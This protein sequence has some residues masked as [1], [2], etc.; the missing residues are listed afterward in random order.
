MFNWMIGTKGILP[1]EWIAKFTDYFNN[2][3]I[4]DE[5]TIRINKINFTTIEQL[6]EEAMVDEAVMQEVQQY[7]EKLEHI[8]HIKEIEVPDALQATLRPYQ[9]EGLNWLNF[10]DDLN[11]GGCLA[12]DMGS[13]QIY[14]DHCLH[15]FSKEQSKKK[16]Q[17]A[18]GAFHAYF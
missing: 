8:D 5:S 6:Y 7:R 3:E 14:P 16:Y 17:P 18:G 1:E 13:G 11:F 4:I 15:T 9:R 10:L 2:A 12:D